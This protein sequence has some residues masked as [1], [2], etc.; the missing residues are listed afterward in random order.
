VDFRPAIRERD[1][2]GVLDAIRTALE[3][4][5]FDKNV[6]PGRTS[7]NMSQVGG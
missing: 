1:K 5:T 6:L 3:H 7:R 2:E 4:K